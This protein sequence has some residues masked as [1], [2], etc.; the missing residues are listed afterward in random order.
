VR[1]HNRLVGHGDVVTRVKFHP[2][3][4]TLASASWDKTVKI[5]QRD[6]EL[7]HTLR[8]HTDAVWSI[9]YSPDGK[10]LVSSS[11]DKTVRIWRVADGKEILVLPHKDWVAC[12]ITSS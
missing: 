2:D 8:G 3:G 6:G 9:N 5:W 12:D 1:E 7:L 11:R 4:K 10:F